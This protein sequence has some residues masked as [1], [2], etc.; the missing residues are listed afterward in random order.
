MPSIINCQS[1]RD[2]NGIQVLNGG[3]GINATLSTGGSYTVSLNRSVFVYKVQTDANGLSTI[4][5]TDRGFTQPPLVQLTCMSPSTTQYAGAQIQNLTSTSLTI[6]SFRTQN[7][8]IIIGGTVIPMVPTSLT[9][10]V[11]VITY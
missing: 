5:L 4:N 9:V 3:T 7:T 6:C 1:Y 2:I 8:A 11:T 10:H